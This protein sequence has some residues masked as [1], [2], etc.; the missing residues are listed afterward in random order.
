MNKQIKKDNGQIESFKR[1]KIRSSLLNA[2]DG[3]CEALI[4]HLVDTIIQHIN[5]EYKDSTIL[6]TQ[7]IKNSVI[8]VLCDLGYKNLAYIYEQDSSQQKVTPPIAQE[9]KGEWSTPALEVMRHRYLRKDNFGNVIESPEDMFWRVAW[10]IAQAEINYD[11]S[12]NVEQKALS[13]YEMMI[14]RDFM[15]NSPTIMNAGG[16]LQM[17]TACFV[18]PVPDS[19]EGILDATKAQGMIQKAG[20]GTGMSF[21]ELRPK[22][23]FVGSTQGVSSGPVSFM[24]LFDAVTNTIKQGGK[25]R[26]ANMGVL[27][28]THPDILDFILCKIPDSSNNSKPLENFNISVAI[29]DDFMEKVKLGDDFD[30]INPRDNSVVATI[31][32]R[33]LFGKLIYSTWAT[34]DPGILFIDRINEDNFLP[35]LGEIKSTNPCLTNDTWVVTKNGPQQIVDIINKPIDILSNGKFYHSHSGFFNTGTREVYKIITK[36]GYSI[37]ATEDHPVL[38]VIELNKESIKT[39]WSKVSDL[40]IGDYIKLSENRGASWSGR[41]SQ[42]EGY[43]LGINLTKDFGL[44]DNTKATTKEIEQSSSE[45]HRGFLMGLFDADGTVLVSGNGN[46]IRLSSIDFDLLLAAQRM[47]Q[48]FGIIS[49]V[50]KERRQAQDNMWP[51]RKIYHSQPQ[52]ELVISK[53]NI[54]I[55]LDKIGFTHISKSKKLTQAIKSYKKSL[56]RERFV[57]EIIQIVPIGKREVYDIQVLGE[58][59]FSAN[60]I[61]VHNCG[62]QSLHP[63]DACNLGSINLAQHV[64]QNDNGNYDIDWKKL[65]KTVNLAVNFLDNVIDMSTYPISEIEK[66]VKLNRRIGLGIMGWH[67]VLIYMEIPYA[68]DRGTALAERV[69][70]FI[71]DKA[72]NASS[73][74]AEKR[75]NFPNYEDSLIPDMFGD[76]PMRNS[77]VNTIAPT[78]TIGI[79][80]GPI[81]SGCE[82]YFGIVWRRKSMLTKEGIEFFEV[83]PLF[84]IIAKREGFYSEHIL[85]KIEE[86]GGVMGIEEIPNKWKNIF[87]CSLDIPYEWHVKMQASFQK[88]VDNSISKTINMTNKATTTDIENAFFMAWEL[89]CK[90]ITVYRDGSKDV[91]VLN[92][93]L[94]ENQNEEQPKNKSIVD[95]IKSSGGCVTCESV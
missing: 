74:L 55:F 46:S 92:I 49:K 69:M 29:T 86:G 37:C 5:A 23:D 17:L 45:F 84:E 36:L 8:D 10:N 76:I 25:R 94:K 18:I 31:D 72:R 13:F 14:K 95:M 71:A 48:R 34:G 75:G 88:Y 82:P 41:G 20:G 63:W 16:E 81:A 1:E 33:D 19:M 68:S 27:S 3:T 35:Q 42:E 40:M 67:D 61:M 52:H 26:G 47:L 64:K 24:Q 93:N 83:N 58:N 78:G 4:D 6:T 22:G 7:E 79:L 65:E 62:E 59:S 57:D 38:R 80:G 73:K 85:N 89:G 70:E 2:Q 39:E 15:P 56:D 12:V 66:M 28:V 51:N 54:K 87:A 91:Q 9:M 21:S 90:G 60:G 11:L 30:L 50:Y 53:D 77:Y 43:L 44:N 32:A